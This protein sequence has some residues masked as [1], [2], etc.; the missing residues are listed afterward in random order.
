MQLGEASLTAGKP[1]EAVDAYEHALRL[2]RDFPR[3]LVSLAGALRVSGELTRAAAT[4]QRAT[5]VEPGTPA[6]WF[7]A[8]AVDFESGHAAEAI[9]KMEKAV[10]LDPD[11]YGGRT[12]LAEILWRTGRNDRAASELENASTAWAIRPHPRQRSSLPREDFIDRLIIRQDLPFQHQAVT[13]S[14]SP[15]RGRFRNP[16]PS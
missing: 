2:Q 6:A 15:R 1:R 5:Q 7:Q 11:L 9:G 16:D 8:G 13:N 14:R 3:G 10:A 4:L 12:G